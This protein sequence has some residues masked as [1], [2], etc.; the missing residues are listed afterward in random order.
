MFF[1]PPFRYETAGRLVGPVGIAA[2]E[3]RKNLTGIWSA[4]LVARVFG[5]WNP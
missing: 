5:R 1:Y 2:L 4:L 3:E